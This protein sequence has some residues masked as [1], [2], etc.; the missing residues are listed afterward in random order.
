MLCLVRQQVEKMAQQVNDTRDLA[1]ASGK[2]AVSASQQ[3]DILRNQISISQQAYITIGRKDGVVAELVQ[4]PNVDD[5]V[6]ILMYFQ[7]GGHLPAQ[8]DWGIFPIPAGPKG[9]DV[10]PFH[11]V[12]LS[13]HITRTRNRKT[14]SV[15]QNGGLNEIGGDALYPAFIGTFPRSQIGRLD[16]T[17]IEGMFEYCDEMGRYSCQYFSLLYRPAP[18]SRF[19]VGLQSD[20][21]V[22]QYAPPANP[23]VEYLPAC[24]TIAEREKDQKT[25]Q[26]FS[27]KE[28]RD[29]KKL[30]KDV[31]KKTNLS[32]KER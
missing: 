19:W 24:K 20:C 25:A 14:G 30:M 15:T 8:F 21:P 4:T 12:T 6:G 32:R 27:A 13:S 3:L 9:A 1:V 2:Q 7:N 10:K 11:A 31:G 29:L 5:P 28:E 22:F 26:G 16:N 23:N 17:A 18:Y